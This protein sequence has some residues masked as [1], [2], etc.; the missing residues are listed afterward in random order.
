MLLLPKNPAI[1]LT[2]L[3]WIHLSAFQT[4]FISSCPL[5]NSAHGIKLLLTPGNWYFSKALRILAQPFLELQL[6]LLSFFCWLQSSSNWIEPI[7]W[8]IWNYTLGYDSECDSVDI[9]MCIFDQDPDNCADDVGLDNQWPP[10]IAIFFFGAYTVAR[11]HVPVTA[12]FHQYSV[13]F[14]GPTII[15]IRAH[16]NTV[17]DRS[18]DKQGRRITTND[19][20]KNSPLH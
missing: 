8:R 16:M 20:F 10:N 1:L 12:I 18:I 17:N 4:I 14:H 7:L 3:L 19:G 13:V 15:F 6:V 11:E 2:K 5:I 9:N